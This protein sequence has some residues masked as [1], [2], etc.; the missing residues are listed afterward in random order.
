MSVRL[1]LL[2]IVLVAPMYGTDP[3]QVAC[4]IH[5]ESDFDVYAVNGI[6][7]GLAQFA[8]DTFEWLVGLALR[9]PGFLHAE[10]VRLYPSQA[11]PVQNVIMLSWAIANGYGPHWSTWE[12]CK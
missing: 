4:I 8:P 11:D 10:V 12:E 7:V 6:H 3:M 5:A 2:I 9:D 1:I